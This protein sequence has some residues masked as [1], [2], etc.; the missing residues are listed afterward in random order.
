M[1]YDELLAKLNAFDSVKYILEDGRISTEKLLEAKPMV[2]LEDIRMAYDKML[3]DMKYSVPK[4]VINYEDQDVKVV[5]AF[6]YTLK[7]YLQSCI[8]TQELMLNKFPET[9]ELALA[10][11]EIFRQLLSMIDE[12]EKLD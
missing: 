3:E 4:V 8:T 11:I 12:F 10:K 6:S 7:L 1:N 9:K 2:Y 5:Y